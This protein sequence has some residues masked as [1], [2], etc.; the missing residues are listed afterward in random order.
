MRDMYL[1]K[2]GSDPGESEEEKGLWS[3][4]VPVSL[5]KI[6]AYVYLMY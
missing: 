4:E 5:K 6:T 3:T 1:G 2:I